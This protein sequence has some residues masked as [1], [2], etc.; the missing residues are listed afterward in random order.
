MDN[1]AGKYHA[2]EVGTPNANDWHYATLT[3]S[4]D[5][6]YRWTNRAGVSWGLSYN[7]PDDKVLQV[8]TDC[9][10]H[11]SGHTTCEV[12]KDDK[13]HGIALMGPGGKYTKQPDA[14]S[15]G[16]HEWSRPALKI[17]SWGSGQDGRHALLMTLASTGADWRDLAFLAAVP[18]STMM[19]RGEPAVLVPGDQSD[20]DDDALADFLARYQPKKLSIFCDSKEN[21]TTEA[22]GQVQYYGMDSLHSV[23]MDLVKAGWAG[24]CSRIVIAPME[25]YAACLLASSLAARI[26]N[27]LFFVGGGAWNKD[28]LQFLKQ[29]LKPSQVV[30]VRGKHMADDQ[31]AACMNQLGN[32]TSVPIT[33]TKDAIA[34]LS[35]QKIT[36]EYLAVVNPNDRTAQVE[37]AS[38]KLSLTASV[39]TAKRNGLVLPIDNIP[40]YNQLGRLEQYDQKALQVALQGLRS[41]IQATPGQDPKHVAIVGGFNVMPTCQTDSKL[42]NVHAVSDIPYG[43]FEGDCCGRKSFRDVPFGRIYAESLTCGSLLAARSVNYNHLVD[44]KWTNEVVEGGTWGFPELCSLAQVTGLCKAPKRMFQKDMDHVTV[45]EANAIFHKGHSG[46]M[47]LGDFVKNNTKALY[48]PAVVI[49]RGCHGAGIDEGD[50]SNGTVAGR[51]LGRGCVAYLGA[52]RTATTPSTLTETTY[53]HEMLYSTEP[54]SVGQ[55]LCVAYN[56]SM[57]NHLDGGPMD[58]Y[59][60]ENEVLLGDPALVPCFVGSGA[61]KTRSMSAS[62]P[63]ASCSKSDDNIVT[64]TGPSEWRKTP[65][66]R[67]QLDEWNYKGDLFTYVAGNVEPETVWGPGY[68]KQDLYYCLTVDLPKGTKVKQVKALDATESIGG[69]EQMSDAGDWTKRWWPTGRFFEQEKNDGSTTVRWRLRLLDYDMPTGDI[70]AELKSARFQL[71]V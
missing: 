14:A 9:C 66:D 29:T 6:G 39:Y 28:L 5:K 34:W 45:L 55:A 50:M 8:G 41:V 68:D 31:V 51:M 61:V 64:V 36:I 22:S 16:S 43:Q 62:G 67:K 38:R 20:K 44:P 25:D 40:V 49:T 71:V 4:G 57:V 65:I 42:G 32:P 56:K 46:A 54:L 63:A 3:P 24:A 10:Y 21:I 19:H 30:M 27:P 37:C 23:T 7:S 13:G 70:K 12:V 18:A 26:R 52:P 48:S 15:G 17:P 59:C 69:K 1:L 53:F 35:S 33:E 2:P 11:G 58:N 47:N 60:F